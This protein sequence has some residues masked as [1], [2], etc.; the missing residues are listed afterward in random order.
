ME[1]GCFCYQA[2]GLKHL[3]LIIIGRLVHTSSGALRWARHAHRHGQVFLSLCQRQAAREHHWCHFGWKQLA[4]WSSMFYE[5]R[6][7]GRGRQRAADFLGPLRHAV[8]ELF[9][10]A[11][12][13]TWISSSI[14]PPA[15]PSSPSSVRAG[16][17]LERN[18]LFLGGVCG[19][20]ASGLLAFVAVELLSS[21]ALPEGLWKGPSQLSCS[22]QVGS[23]A[24]CPR[25][26]WRCCLGGWQMSDGTSGA[27]P[28]MAGGKVQQEMSHFR[29]CK[30]EGAKPTICAYFLF[31]STAWLLPSISYRHSNLV[32]LM[33]LVSLVTNAMPARRLALNCLYN[34]S[35]FLKV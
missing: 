34:H 11:A 4:V 32:R 5:E 2:E 26:G 12:Q 22:G 24:P 8:G 13:E 6:S 18:R 19:S 25:A 9:V 31:F 1:E 23:D 27:Q 14:L 3:S 33:A 21:N 28:N 16:S 29:S 17:S 7:L 30:A 20:F 15:S 35:A 10:A